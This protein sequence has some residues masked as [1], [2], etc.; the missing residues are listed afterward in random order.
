MNINEMVPALEAV[1]FSGGEPTSIVQLSKAL[2]SEPED[3]EK[4]AELLK[5]RLIDS[6]SGIQLL[7][8]DNAYQLATRKEYEEQ[9]KTAFDMRRRAP[10]SQA[11]L[12]VLAVIAY[13]QPVT[14]SFVE[15]VRGVDCSGVIS[16]LVEKNLIEECGR[17][18]LPGRPL[19]YGTTKNFLRCFSVSSL[20][21]LPKL[22]GK[23][24]E[25]AVDLGEQ[26]MVSEVAE[27]EPLEVEE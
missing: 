19:L 7:R 27:M 20:S 6:G 4:A 25:T 24:N 23:E 9:I 14:K 26:L 21:E 1:L 3:I 15:Q 10:L 17:L 22:P 16:T 2:E 11:A 5:K 12:E 13:N 18:E 8:L